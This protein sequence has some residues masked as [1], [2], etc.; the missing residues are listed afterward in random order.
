MW[1]DLSDVGF[2]DVRNDP[3][4]SKVGCDGEQFWCLKARRYRLADIDKS[5]YYYPV[6]RCTYYRVFEVDLVLVQ[7]G[8]SLCDLRFRG[9]YLSLR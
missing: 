2:V 1:A 3:H 5:R 7:C 8:L 6:D 9:S 4:F